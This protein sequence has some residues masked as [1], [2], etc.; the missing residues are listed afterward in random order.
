MKENG[1]VKNVLKK[2]QMLNHIH[3]SEILLLSM[4]ILLVIIGYFFSSPSYS[5]KPCHKEFPYKIKVIYSCKPDQGCNVLLEN[6][7]KLA[8]VRSAELEKQPEGLNC[9]IIK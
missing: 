4:C 2:K 3:K 5:P 7:L 9:E 1:F 6:G 8:R